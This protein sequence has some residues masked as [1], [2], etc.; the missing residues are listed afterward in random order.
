MPDILP[1]Q[2]Q[3]ELILRQRH[4]RRG[5]VVLDETLGDEAVRGLPQAGVRMPDDIEVIIHGSL[6]P[7]TPPLPTGIHRLGFDLQELLSRGL[8]LIDGVR[9]GDEVPSYLEMPALFASS[10]DENA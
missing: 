6:S 8:R 3:I 2:A 9:R 7:V 5:L 10:S 1:Q 4:T